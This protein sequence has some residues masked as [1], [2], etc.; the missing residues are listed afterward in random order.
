MTVILLPAVNVV[1]V[2]SDVPSP[3]RSCPLD[4]TLVAVIAPVPEPKRIPPSVRVVA[5]VPPLATANVADNP[6]AFPVIS[7]AVLAN[8]PVVE[9][10]V[11]V[12]EPLV[13]V[14]SAFILIVS[15]LEFTAENPLVA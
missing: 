8:V 14:P 4:N 15:A 12:A 9:G 10:N 2:G 1:N 7:S 5:P 6:A 13:K 11:I 3:I